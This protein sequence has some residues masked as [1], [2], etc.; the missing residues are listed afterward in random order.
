[1]ITTPRQRRL[2]ESAGT[3]Y[4][5]LRDEIRAGRIGLEEIRE[6]VSCVVSSDYG[7]LSLLDTPRGGGGGGGGGSGGS[8]RS[9]GSDE[10]YSALWMR[11]HRRPLRRGFPLKRTQSD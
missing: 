1:M 6:K 10:S 8:P 9:R 3:D 4:T 7:V 11:A 5:T 2:H